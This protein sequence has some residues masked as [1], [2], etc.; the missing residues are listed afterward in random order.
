[1]ASKLAVA[2]SRMRMAVKSQKIERT[3]T[4]AGAG[5]LLGAAESAGK[6]QVGIAGIPS[7][8][9]LAIGGHLIGM[10]SGGTLGRLGANIGDA[11]LACYGYA[12]G[13]NRAF[14]AGMTDFAE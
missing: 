3:V 4:M 12:A 6:L 8:L 2:R 7:K 14:V 10:K 13:K 5:L 9:A 11:C 1:M